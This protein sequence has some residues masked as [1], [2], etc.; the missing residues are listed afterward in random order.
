M[1]MLING[2]ISSFSEVSCTGS[3]VVAVASS[4]PV[5]IQIWT[6]WRNEKQNAVSPMNSCLPWNDSIKSGGEE[7]LLIDIRRPSVGEPNGGPQDVVRN[8][9]GIDERQGHAAELAV[10]L[11][12]E[13]TK[14]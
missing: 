12:R 4:S 6:C 3:I 9:K 5:R 11:G 8:A 1:N 10:R 2:C 7:V 13:K 14:I